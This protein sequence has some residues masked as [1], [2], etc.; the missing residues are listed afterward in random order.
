MSWLAR[1]SH[2][3]IHLYRNKLPVGGGGGGQVHVKL[4]ALVQQ[5]MDW[6][7]LS[8]CASAPLQNGGEYSFDALQGSGAKHFACDSMKVHKLLVC[9]GVL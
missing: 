9:M 5:C 4:I 8:A 3:G 1:P 2:A 7:R 6:G